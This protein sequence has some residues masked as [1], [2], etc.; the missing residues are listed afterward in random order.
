MTGASVTPFGLIAI[1][2]LGHSVS[3]YGQELRW[4]KLIGNQAFESPQR[5]NSPA[6]RGFM[7][8]VRWNDGLGISGRTT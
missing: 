2:F 4:L 5:L 8:K 1:Q 6:M 7:R 3:S